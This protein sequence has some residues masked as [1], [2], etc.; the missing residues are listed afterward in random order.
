MANP[1]FSKTDNNILAT[2]LD[3]SSLPRLINL[4]VTASR[5][6]PN[7]SPILVQNSTAQ[8]GSYFSNGAARVTPTVEVNANTKVSI[9]PNP[10]NNTLAVSID[11]KTDNGIVDLQI[12]DIAGRV[13]LSQH[14]KT[15][16]GNNTFSVNTQSLENGIYFAQ[17]NVSNTPV[18]IKVVKL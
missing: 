17:F 9:N 12:I 5:L 6:E 10:F 15:T 11:G 8:F 4:P 3:G 16:V 7:G 1:N 18:T 2:N 13:V 14:Y